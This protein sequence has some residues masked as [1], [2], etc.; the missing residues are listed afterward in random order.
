MWFVQLFTDDPLMKLFESLPH[1]M[2]SL[3][4][5]DGRYLAANQA[6]AERASCKSPAGVRGKRAADLFAPEL[7]I[8]Y[9]AQD[10]ALL[11][12]GRP[13]LRQLEL[14]TRPNG[15][16]GWYVTNKTL[17]FGADGVP[18][19]IAAAS[20]DEW[21]PANR[22]GMPNLEG[23]VAQIHEHFAEPLS[24]KVLAQKANMTPEL[25]GRRMR[26][27]LG[28]SP[29]QLIVR[30]RV[31]EAIHRIVYS[32]DHLAEVAA[33]CGFFDQASMTRQVKHLLGVSPGI[34]RAAARKGMATP[35]RP[36]TVV[37]QY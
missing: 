11:R 31:E 29:Q 16:H 35:I 32:N 27:H 14:I 2:F 18:T 37:S 24:V 25:L 13:V 12:S 21:V 20:V 34:L 1:V 17:I 6:F 23:V 33:T 7:A 10:A 36:S 26:R 30:V 4:G 3:K 15:K 28:V 9:E 19:A 22:S 5:I 8:S